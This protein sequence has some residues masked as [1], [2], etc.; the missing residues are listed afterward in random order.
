MKTRLPLA[1]LPLLFLCSCLSPIGARLHVGYIALEPTGD[2]GLED[3]ISSMP[4]GDIKIEVDDEFNL[5]DAGAPYLRA[6]V[7]IAD[8]DFSLSGFHYDDSADTT[9]NTEFGDIP[10]GSLVHSELE[11][12]NVKVAATYKLIEVPF[13]HVGVGAAIDYFAIDMDVFSTAPVVAFEKVDFRAPVPMLYARA[14]ANV[15]IVSANLEVGW[16]SVDLQDGKGNFLDVDAMVTVSPTP[17]LDLF[18]GY[19]YISIDALG[20]ADGQDFDTDLQLGG[21]YVGGGVTF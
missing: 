8:W 16:L 6:E 12:Y 7:N 20:E 3:S 2:F 4:L 13:A 9:L 10:A 21:W 14:G 17:V 15:G 1:V 18:V 5:E 11:V 19:R